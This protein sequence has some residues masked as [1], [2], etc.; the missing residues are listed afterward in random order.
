MIDRLSRIG[1]WLPYPAII[2]VGLGLGRYGQYT[3][4]YFTPG[5]PTI[6]SHS[7]GIWIA[8]VT[9]AIA[10]VA[11]LLA[12]WR[13]PRGRWIQ[14]FLGITLIAWLGRW[15]L[16]QTHGDL[17][18]LTIWLYPAVV[19]M[20]WTKFPDLRTLRTSLMTLGW[21]GSI[22]LI[23]TRASELFGLVPMA[24]ISPDL[25]AFEVGEYWLPLAGWL[26]PEGR[27]PGP[28]GGT[29]Y[30]GA[31]GALLLVLAFALRGKSSWVFGSVGVVVLL[32]TSSRGAIAAAGAGVAVAVL[33]SD[34]RPLRSWSFR[35]RALFA[36]LGS[37]VVLALVVRTNIGL[38]GRT[39]FWIDFLELWQVSPLIGVGT[40]G[41]QEGTQATAVSGTAHSLYI[42]EL[43]RNGLMG[44]LLLLA[45]LTVAIIMA[46]QSAR[47]GVSGPLAMLIAL[48]VLGIVN[49][50]FSWLS[51]SLMWM[52]YLL[53]ILW[54]A[55]EVQAHASTNPNAQPH[56][57]RLPHQFTVRER[58]FR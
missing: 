40:S 29:A 23:W 35:V 8:W 51:P 42:D 34:W 1:S 58:G 24:P 17:L 41:Y 21:V 44:F 13:L 57:T 37:A 31:L 10:A 52:F 5:L 16:A 30:T 46:L 50:P 22:L 54:A 48:L 7:P 43:A 53:P 11:W 6:R 32:L 36:A 12:P 55:A 15:L 45:G 33:F 28:M 56:P 47:I 18:D 26:G 14:I 39:S 9:L 49:T 2:I 19:L 27:W 3:W 25:V 4:Q 20:L 38:T